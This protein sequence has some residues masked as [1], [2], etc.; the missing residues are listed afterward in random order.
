M[1]LQI[2]F[3]LLIAWL[4]GVVGMY[5]IGATSCMYCCWSA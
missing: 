3:T 4:F 5:R 2:A 1:L